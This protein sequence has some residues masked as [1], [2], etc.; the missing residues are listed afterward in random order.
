VV[1]D[2]LKM[3]DV[4]MEMDWIGSHSMRRDHLRNYDCEMSP[5]DEIVDD[6][7]VR[8]HLVDEICCVIW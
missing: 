3:I 4:A 2:A 7:I 1:D 6:E 5:L 8:I